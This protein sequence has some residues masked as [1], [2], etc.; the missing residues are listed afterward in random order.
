MKK[1]LLFLLALHAS[2][3]VAQSQASVVPGRL[4]VKFKP[5]AYGQAVQAHPAMQT[6]GLAAAKTLSVGLAGVDKLNARYKAVSMYRLFPYAGKHE[7]L[8]QKFGLHL[9]YTIVL[10]E[11][12]DPRGVAEKYT[13]DNDIEW[14][15]PMP[16]IRSVYTSPR[17]T[18]SGDPQYGAAAVFPDDDLYPDQWHYHN[19]GQ[20][21]GTPGVDI[22]L[23][24]AWNITKG[25]PDV[26]V[27]IV[28][29]G[30]DITHEDLKDN[31]WVNEA[32]LHGEPGVDDDD[33]GYIDDVHGFNFVVGAPAHIVASEHGTHVAGTIAAA[34]NNGIGVAGIAGG[35]GSGNG[36]RLMVCQTMT[37]EVTSGYIT[38]AIAYAANNGA[39]ILQNSW[40]VDD[41]YQW[42][43][44]AIQYFIAAAGHTVSKP[45]GSPI[46][47][48]SGTPMNGG[49]VIVAAGNEASSA[50]TYPAS[51]D[52]VLA[53]AAV[54]S[55]GK[56]TYYSNYGS[57]VDISAP[58]GDYYNTGREGGTS[59][60]EARTVLSTLPN[61]RYGWMQGTSMACPHV[62]GVAALALSRYGSETYTPELLRDRLF[63][64]ATPLPDEPRYI[65]GYM[66]AGLVN[67]LQAVSDF[68]AMTGI[69]LSPVD[70]YLGQIDTLQ[71]DIQPSDATDQR[72]RWT[73]S[74]PGIVKID[75]KKGIITGLVEG[76]ATI[77]VT[78]NECCFA[79]TATVNVLPIPA[80]SIRL[81]P[82]ELLIKREETS[83]LTVLYY[84]SDM[85]HKEVGWRSRD[86]GIAEVDD[87][88]QVTGI[89]LG[90][91][92]IVAAIQDG[93]GEKDSCLVTVVQPV[94]GVEIIPAGIIRLVKG[95]TVTLHA[96]IIPSNAHNKTVF[97]TSSSAK[98]ASFTDNLLTAKAAGETTVIVRTD[99]GDRAATARVEVSEIEHAPE[100]FSPNNDGVNEYFVC[101]LDSRDTYTLAVFDRS[102]QVHYRSP[103]YK[104]DWDGTANTGPHRGNKVPANTYFYTLSAKNTG[105]TTTGFVVVKY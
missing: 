4:I 105:Q 83:R 71:A 103:D 3:C 91:V 65:N 76:S 72:I 70:I 81:S 79:A 16:V 92:Y 57:W 36:A 11:S 43:R 32:E 53:V 95:D 100:G 37:D 8:Q 68:V 15:E 58:G 42:I 69:T 59:A 46:A 97:W 18:F 34:T 41:H 63:L 31:L 82:Q 56:R 25:S 54:T 23:P 17:L 33:N 21:D 74:H 102:G 86:T 55:K 89:D 87:N 47:V 88:G 2:M 7:P 13:K 64:T 96:N 104:N 98:V 75:E 6:Q 14:A 9:W 73:S 19:P 40:S 94:T 67:A 29:S 45:E 62:S 80:D 39:V 30:V 60:V 85:T 24:E 27:G 35:D 38:A 50:R 44:V 93:T 22:D 10:D 61:N 5:A 66:G 28:D 99:D 1:L 101:T 84:P 78:T 20:D 90:S 49:I 77:T 52:E 26:I 12:L 51:Y 48:R